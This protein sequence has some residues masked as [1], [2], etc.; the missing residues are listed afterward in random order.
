M[1]STFASRL[2]AARKMRS[3]SM[4]ELCNKIGNTVTKQ[5]I[6]KYENAQMMP[7]STVLLEIADALELDVDYFFRPLKLDVDKSSIEFR[8]KSKLSKKDENAIKEEIADKLERYFEVDGLLDK[9]IQPKLISV[10]KVS[11]SSEARNAALELRNAW[12][13]GLESIMNIISVAENNGV[14]VMGI[15]APKGFDGLSGYVSGQYPFV[16]I[17]FSS[18]PERLRFSFSHELGHFCMKFSEELSPKDKEMLCHVFASEFLLPSSILFERL[19]RKRSRILFE[20]LEQIQEEYGISIDAIMHKAKDLGVISQNYYQ[21]YCIRHRS[22]K[23]FKQKCDASRFIQPDTSQFQHDVY[24]ALAEGFISES[25]A[26]S[27]LRGISDSDEMV[28][29][30]SF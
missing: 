16:A 12:N 15:D 18:T 27:L 28:F 7:S 14:K 2:K 8:K 25:K 4:D 10:E 19:G 13:L 3:L 20:E 29:L 6:H 22:D 26:N 23:S 17:N 9:N 21:S 30:E 1:D 24:R 11:S 5:A